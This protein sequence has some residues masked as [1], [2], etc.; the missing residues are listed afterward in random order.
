MESITNLTCIKLKKCK[1]IHQI[2]N[3]S[4]YVMYKFTFSINGYLKSNVQTDRKT[5]TKPEILTHSK[6]TLILKLKDDA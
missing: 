6:L 3:D 2:S 5:D 4:T 1:F